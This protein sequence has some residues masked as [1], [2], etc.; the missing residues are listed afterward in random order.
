MAGLLGDYNVHPDTVLEVS[1][2]E[3]VEGM[4]KIAAKIVEKEGLADLDLKD[5]NMALVMDKHKYMGTDLVVKGQE[6]VMG[7]KKTDPEALERQRVKEIEEGEIDPLKNSR[8]ILVTL[9]V[10]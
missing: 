4:K 8:R 9:V 6:A 2:A 5:L 10:S 1:D 7:G 3:G